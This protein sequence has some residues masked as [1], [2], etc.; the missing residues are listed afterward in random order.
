MANHSL[1]LGFADY[2]VPGER[3]AQHLGAEFVLVELHRFPDGES[4][5]TLPATLPE[6]VVICR[7]LDHPNDKLVELMLCAETAR[8]LGARRLTLVAP[9]LCYMRQDI[10][11]HPGE[12]VSQKIIGAFLAHHFDAVITVDPHLHRISQLSEA[13]PRGTALALTATA[14]MA[15]FIT[16]QIARPLIVGPDA[17]SEQWVRAIAEPAGLDFAVASKERLG[18]R[19]VRTTLPACDYRGRHVVL[20]D[21]MASTGR[22]LIAVAS[23]LA[24]RGAAAIDCLVTHPLFAD[25][26]TSQLHEAGVNHIWSSDAILHGS[27][28]ITLAPLLAAAL[29]QLP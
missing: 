15:Q 16:Q 26:A 17:E 8:Q 18:D 6:H 5:L 21:D 25:D 10:A 12:A 19:Q 3:L 14:L 27:N 7:S 1:V 11:F 28:V 13:I 23:Q 20:V 9:Y 24:Q 22:T 4:K 29:R 2:A